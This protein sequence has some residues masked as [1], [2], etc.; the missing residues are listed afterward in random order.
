MTYERKN[1]SRVHRLKHNSQRRRPGAEFG[2]DGK[3]FRRPR[4]LN[5]NFFRKN[6]SFSR[7]K[8]LMTFF[9]HR[10]GFSVFLCLLYN[11]TSLN[12][13]GT[14]AWAVPHLKFWGDRPP[15]PPPGLRLYSNVICTRNE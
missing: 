8:F 11:T 7:P 15:S 3:K 4:F 13:G 6:F 2:G 9:S 10:P 1:Y 14:N 12:I 5:D